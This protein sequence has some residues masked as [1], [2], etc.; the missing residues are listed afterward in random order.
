MYTVNL[1]KINI[2]SFMGRNEMFYGK[3]I[4]L[5]QVD[6]LN[7]KEKVTKIEDELE[8]AKKESSGKIT[9]DES[10]KSFAE[11]HVQT[12]VYGAVGIILTGVLTSIIGLVGIE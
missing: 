5:L 6:I 12:I 8:E 9:K 7:L 4:A 11:K 2:I 10:E 1:I 3:K